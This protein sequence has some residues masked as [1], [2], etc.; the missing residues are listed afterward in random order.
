[1]TVATNEVRTNPSLWRIHVASIALQICSNVL[2]LVDINKAKSNYKLSTAL[3]MDNFVGEIPL[4]M[5]F[6]AALIKILT[7]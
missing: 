6:S 1:M 2:G 7:S 4:R 5:L 3:R